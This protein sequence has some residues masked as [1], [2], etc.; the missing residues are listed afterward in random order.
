MPQ[1]GVR[2]C[3]ENSEDHRQLHHSFT[4]SERRRGRFSCARV[5]PGAW[6]TVVKIETRT[7]EVF[8]AHEFALPE[9]FDSGSD[10]YARQIHDPARE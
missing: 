9:V 7:F 5:R 3:R 4:I 1:R 10:K 2:H 6:R 8:V